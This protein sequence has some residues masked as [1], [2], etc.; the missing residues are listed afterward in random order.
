MVTHLDEYMDF[1]ATSDYDLR[2][3]DSLQQFLGSIEEIECSFAIEFSCGDG[4]YLSD[5][6]THEE[7]E[8]YDGKVCLHTPP[9]LNAIEVS[10]SP[11]QMLAGK[12]Y[13]FT[14]KYS[15]KTEEQIF[16]IN[17]KK[18]MTKSNALA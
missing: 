12:K 18:R 7:L 16:C 1:P 17:S 11:K 14:V 9:R 2:A 8:K 15:P 13:R 3:F 5:L 4:K 10:Q 6:Y